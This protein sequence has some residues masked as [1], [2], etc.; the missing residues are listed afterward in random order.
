MYEYNYLTSILGY[1]TKN[2]TNVHF[3]YSSLKKLGGGGGGYDIRNL[4]GF[5]FF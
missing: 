1:V 2:M 3:Y 5:Y 4:L